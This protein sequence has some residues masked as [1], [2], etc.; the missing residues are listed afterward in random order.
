MGSELITV[1]LA[2]TPINELRGTIPLAMTAFQFSPFKSFFLAVLGNMIPIFLLLWF[3]QNL[4]ESLIK[5]SKLIKKFFFW[6]F[7]RTRK[8]F[9]KK[10]AFYGNLGLILL[11]AIP[12]PL[13]GAWTGTIA[14]FLFGIPYIRSLGLIFIGVLIAGLIVTLA[15]IGITSII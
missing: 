5:R 3:W 13:T 7:K 8:R 14:A 4:S 9:Y 11:V 10:H 2:M 1:L 12:L 6:L 15:T